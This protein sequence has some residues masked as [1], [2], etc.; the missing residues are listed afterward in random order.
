[1]NFASAQQERFFYTRMKGAL[2]I[3]PTLPHKPPKKVEAKGSTYMPKNQINH[4]LLK[5]FVV[6]LNNEGYEVEA[7]ILSNLMV[8]RSN[9]LN[10]RTNKSKGGNHR[11]G[12]YT[13]CLRVQKS[14]AT[15]VYRRLEGLPLRNILQSPRVIVEYLRSD[16]A[17]IT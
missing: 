11:I 14:L 12:A 7:R 6:L 17:C 5:R 4:Q 2:M 1:M 8:A 10:A 3:T 13:A 15:A 9:Y 16:C